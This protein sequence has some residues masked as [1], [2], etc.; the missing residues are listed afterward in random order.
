[1]RQ[2][3]ATLDAEIAER[4]ERYNQRVRDYTAAMGRVPGNLVAF[5]GL[6]PPLR[7]LETGPLNS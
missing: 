1:L 3:H 4:R 7:Q 6:F 5:T 2:R